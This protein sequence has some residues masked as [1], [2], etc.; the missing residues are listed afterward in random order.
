MKQCFNVTGMSCAACSARV[1]KCVSSLSG[2]DSVSVNLL[3]NN[4]TV[5]YDSS[6]IAPEEIIKAVENSGYGAYLP[7]GRDETVKTA[8]SGKNNNDE[9]NN[10][11]LRLVLSAV[12]SVLLSYT[13]MGH[14]LPLPLPPFLEGAHNIGINAFTQFLLTLPVIA[15]NSKYYKNG[16]LSLFHGAPNMDT[17][18]AVG[19]GAS[20]IYGIY[21]MYGILYGLG[22]GDMETV[23]RFGENLYFE[24]VGMILTL[25]TLGKFFESRAKKRTV[26]AITGL[27]DLSPKTAFIYTD[28]QEQEISTADIKTGD[29]LCVR[30]GN[31]VPVD[32]IIIEGS[33]SVDESSLTGESIP[34]EKTAGS[35]VIGGT[36]C[37]SGFFRMKAEKV[38]ADT[39]LSQIIQLVDDATSSKAPVQK[40]ADKIS[41]VFV[42][43]VMAAAL[44]AAAVWLLLG[45]GADQAFTAGVSVLVISCP[46]ALGLATP[47]AVMVGTGK[48][49]ANG[50]LI[51]SAESLELAHKTDTVVLDKT[52]TVT[53]GIPDV[54]D[55]ITFGDI[56]RKELLTYAYS[57]ERLSEHPIAQAIV[58]CGEAN[59]I[60]PF[61]ISNITQTE[62]AGISASSDGNEYLAG[63][64]RIAKPY[65]TD[66]IKN[67]ANELAAQGKTPVFFIRNNKLD[68][69][70]AAADHIKPTSKAAVK[71]LEKMGINV[72]MLTGDNKV[73]AEAV[74]KAAG[75]K[76]IISEVYPADKEKKISSLIDSGH[77]T[78]MVGDGINDAPA[79]A[80]AD[81][82]IAIGA[83][84]DIAIDSADI[85]LMKNDLYD[86]VNTI[87]LSRAVM[88]TIK[89]N[90][91]WA[92]FYNAA[93]IPIAAGVFY[94][95][96]LMLNPMIGAAAMSFS[97]LCVVT[98]ALRLRHFRMKYPQSESLTAEPENEWIDSVYLN[99]DLSDV[100]E[101]KEMNENTVTLKVEGMMC[102]KCVAHVKKALE[103]TQGVA[104]ADVDLKKGIAVVKL[105]EETAP[106]KLIEAVTDAGYEASV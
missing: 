5:E 33:A 92:F 88:R 21:A 30:A 25:V 103:K 43:V 96:G 10:M 15:V 32:G 78:A 14:M 40:L 89:Q 9:H 65:M 94:S 7:D 67:K 8:V 98:N 26:D 106:E 80:R 60:T 104:A 77:C 84:T 44:T 50:I 52:G 69:I 45:Y 75:I 11:L 71:E 95:F 63:N 13:A 91:F 39:A 86:V 99:D 19:S 100:K 105:T 73:T 74:G 62:G 3:K 18:I 55:I 36:V 6:I 1:D 29:I 20:M 54:T 35:S 97:S 37:R 57:I 17:L 81:I 34:A 59:N 70:I 79:L 28:G 42:P 51:K 16:F 22:M 64:I 56:S 2:V 83:G 41:G 24:S 82:G 90:L 12:F 66:V 102:E 61:E 23:H 87:R 38:G 49:S 58:R 93:G 76:N 48:G 101:V 72:I 85:V 27:M 46:C 4:M 31:S 53:S 47:T 68:G